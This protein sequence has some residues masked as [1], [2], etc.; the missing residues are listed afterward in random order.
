VS[1]YEP[2]PLQFFTRRSW[3]PWLVVGVTCIGGFIGQLD[4]SIVQL[5]LPTLERQFSANLDAVS[6]VAIAYLLAFASTLPIFARLSETKGRKL[7]Y[8][9]GYALFTVASALCGMVSDLRLLIVCRAIQGIGGALCGANSITILVKA[10]GPS[11]LGRAMGL[12]AAAQA[13]GISTGPVIGGLILAKLGWRWIFLVSVPFGLAGLIVGW[14]ALS[15]TPQPTASKRFD[16]Q[17]ALLLTP[18][19]TSVVLMLNEGQAWGLKS[20]AMLCAL[21][22]A[23]IFLPLFVWREWQQRDPLIDLHL[24]RSSAFSGGLAAVSLS[25]ALLYSMF[26]LMSFLFIHGL[27]ESPALAGLH[28]ALIPIALGLVAPISGSIYA[29]VGARTMT[30]SAMLLCMCALV[31]LSISMAGPT[32]YH[33]GVMGALALFGAGLGMFIAPNNSATMAAA[34]GNRTG[35]AGGMVN[36]MRALGCAIGIATAS[37]TLSW[38]LFV[39]TGNGHRTINVPTHILLA[40]TADVLWVLG[41]FAVAAAGCAFLRDAVAQHSK[42]VIGKR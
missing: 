31:L 15:Q 36:L 17:G 16:W 3:Y 29:R 24:F 42:P 33:Y 34:P 28:L 35:E 39:Y 1:R 38:R 37:V 9:A 2:A 11:R 30:T 19:L 20:A 6:W 40:A 12:F 25:Y 22:V 32:V 10:A 18:A 21:L 14:L 13:V 7:L 26:F 4:A 8:L 23:A 5:A 41:G 27:K